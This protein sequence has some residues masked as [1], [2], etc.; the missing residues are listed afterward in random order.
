MVD[1]SHRG[2]REGRHRTDL[3]ESVLEPFGFLEPPLKGEFPDTLPF[4]TAAPWGAG[5]T[6]MRSPS[7]PEA[8]RFR[9]RA[10][11]R[12]WSIFG[13]YVVRAKWPW[14]MI[15]FGARA[16]EWKNLR[17]RQ[18]Q[19]AGASPFAALKDFKPP[20]LGPRMASMAW[21]CIPRSAMYRPLARFGATSPEALKVGRA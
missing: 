2:P 21:P 13:A 5:T 4:Q 14:T 18:A 15:R 20:R 1:G 8:G 12:M 17:P 9:G 7:I 16:R 19:S 10:R 6:R 11:E 3:R